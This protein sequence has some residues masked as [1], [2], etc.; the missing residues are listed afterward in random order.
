MSTETNTTEQEEKPSTL[1]TTIN[2]IEIH[3]A[4]F[5]KG[6]AKGLK[7]AFPVFKSGAEAD[8]LYGVEATAQL[9]NSRNKAAIAQKVI[10][11]K[12]PRNV[13]A[14]KSA[15]IIADLVKQDPTGLIHTAQEAYD[16]RPGER[17]PGV[18]EL[19][20]NLMANLD[21]MSGDEIKAQ[22]M[23]LNSKKQAPRTPKTAAPAAV[24]A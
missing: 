22:L 24:A 21:N 8:A 9:I 19:Y 23:L 14:E 4:E 5:E 7:Y 20:K 11:N 16:H 15:E 18:K 2:G 17:A 3:V 12:L 1:L 13:T 6:D 10:T